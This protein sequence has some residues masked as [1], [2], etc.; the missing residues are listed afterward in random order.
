MRIKN[1]ARFYG[2]LIGQIIPRMSKIA[3]KKSI[4][5]TSFWTVETVIL[6]IILLPKYAPTKAEKVAAAMS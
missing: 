6:V 2:T 4:P 5:A 3:N 1:F